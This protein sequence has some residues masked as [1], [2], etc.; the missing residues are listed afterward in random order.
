[1]KFGLKTPLRKFVGL[2]IFD[3]LTLCLFLLWCIKMLQILKFWMSILQRIRKLKKVEKHIFVSYL[4][5]KSHKNLFFYYSQKNVA[6]MTA[7]LNWFQECG[8]AFFTMGNNY[9]WEVWFLLLDQKYFF[10]AIKKYYL[11]LSH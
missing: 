6:K 11:I 2:W 7:I 10:E 1:M 5:L 3:L 9:V 4:E 8:W